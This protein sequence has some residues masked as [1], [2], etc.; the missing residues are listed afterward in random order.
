MRIQSGKFEGKLIE[1]VFLKQPDYVQW[2]IYNAP[3]N[4]LVQAFKKLIARYDSIQ[5]CEEKC[6]SCGSLATRASAY[7]NTPDLMFWCGKCNPYNSGARSGT[8]TIVNSFHSAMSHVDS[9]AGGNRNDKRE[10][11]RNLA[12]AKGLPKKITEKAALEFFS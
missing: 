10:I 2:M 6:H 11:I 9:T 3:G 7:A 4:A 12:E 8:L 1:V 5:I